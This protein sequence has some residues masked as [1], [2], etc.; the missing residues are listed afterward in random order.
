MAAI[1]HKTRGMGGGKT[2][3]VA[4]EAKAILRNHKR[5]SLERLIWAK[6]ALY[7][8]K[9]FAWDDL[10]DVERMGLTKRDDD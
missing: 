4:T 6:R 8:R 2:H 7:K 9:M 1:K 10:S 5:E 3:S